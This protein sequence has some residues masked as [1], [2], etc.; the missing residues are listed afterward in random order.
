MLS[1]PPS[2]SQ[3]TAGTQTNS[4]P[5]QSERVVAVGTYLNSQGVPQPNPHPVT[6]ILPP[7]HQIQPRT[8][9]VQQTQNPGFVPIVETTNFSLKQKQVPYWT[10]EDVIN[11]ST[12]L[13][14]SLN[15]SDT[16][17]SAR[18]DG[19]KLASL[20]TSD[21]WRDIGVTRFGDIRKLLKGIHAPPFDDIYRAMEKLRV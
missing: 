12:E 5:L 9:V 1:Q 18:V 17:R 15:Y 3:P 2:L 13:R 8:H 4:R 20:Q 10:V 21:H 7:Q 11:W 6:T 19:A 14:L 16:F